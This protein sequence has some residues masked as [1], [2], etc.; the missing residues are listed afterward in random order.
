MDYDAKLSDFLKE[1][2]NALQAQWDHILMI[3]TRIMEDAGAPVSN[4][5]VIAIC[6]LNM[7]P[8]PLVNMAFNG[9][10]PMLTGFAPEVYASWPWLRT[11]S[12]NLM[13]TPPPHIDR[14]AMDVLWDEIVHQ[15]GSGPRVA[16]VQFPTATV[17]MPANHA[18][19]GGKE[20][21]VGAR[22]GTTKSVLHVSPTSHS[23][24]RCS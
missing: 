18:Y 8:T 2:E 14:M 7:L 15:L 10:V 20:G 22:N 19:S 6:L 17:S 12:L 24:V 5:L 23:P 21:E 11:N 3:V 4:G 9:A 16:T 13:H 1:T